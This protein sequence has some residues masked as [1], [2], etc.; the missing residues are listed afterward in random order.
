MFN[1]NGNKTVAFWRRKKRVAGWVKS[2]W[3]GKRRGEIVV[4]AIVSKL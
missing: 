1:I 2:L 4:K 3:F